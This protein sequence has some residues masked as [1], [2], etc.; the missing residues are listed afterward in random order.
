MQEY[1]TAVIRHGLTA[2]AGWLVTKGIIDQA[3]STELI[4]AVVGAI[5]V[6]WSLWHKF[7]LNKA[8]KTS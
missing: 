6:A 1:V 5:G 7:L 8:S 4:G 2:G 3:G